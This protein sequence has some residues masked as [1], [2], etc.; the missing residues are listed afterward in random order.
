MYDNNN[1]NNDGFIWVVYGVIH[2][3]LMTIQSI[4]ITP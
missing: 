3:V 4:I 1:D 2:L